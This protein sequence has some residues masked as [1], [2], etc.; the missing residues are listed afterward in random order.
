M[1]STIY[2]PIQEDLVKVEDRLRSVGEVDFPWL[3][4]LLDYSLGDGGKRIRPA[5]VLLSGKFYNY[6][7]SYLLP[8]AT[9]VEVLHTATL[10]HDDAIDNSLVRRGHPTINKVWGEDKAILL[11]DYLLAKSEEL[12]ADTQNLRVIKLFAQTIMA[13]SSGELNQAFSAFNLEQTR[14]QYLQRISGKTACLLCLATESGAILSQA[15]GKSVE[16]LKGYGYNLGIA[17]Q[18]ADDILDFVGTEAEMGKPVGSDLAQGTLTLPAILLLERYPEDNPVRRL[19]Q[20]ED[21]QKNIELALEL[22]RN[23]SIIQECYAVASDYCARACQNLNLLP[24]NASRRSLIKLA[25]Y[26]VSRRK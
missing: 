20:N 4:K 14:Q 25:D 21:K 23:S 6:D 9:S 3:S 17:F 10:V 13:I 8:M 16:A 22:V 18:I 24:D 26:V 12:V 7:L 15:P 1:L 11:G 2:E 5:L 19:F